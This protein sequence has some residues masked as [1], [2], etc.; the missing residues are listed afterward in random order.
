MV[1]VS[2]FFFALLLWGLY[3]IT[4]RC[5][6][7]KEQ[8]V[9]LLGLLLKI[10]SALG[11]G[12]LYKY[13]Y[14][15]GDTFNYLHDL[16]L[17]GQGAKEGYYFFY[18]PRAWFFVKLVCPFYL[19]SFSNYWVLAVVLS[20]LSF[21]STWFFYTELKRLNLRKINGQIAL[22]FVPTVV[23]WTSG[24]MKETVSFAVINLLFFLLL[25]IRR[26][27]SFLVLH[28]VCFGLLSLLL[29]YLKYYLF[30]PIF[31]LSVLLFVASLQQHVSLRKLAL[32]LFLVLLLLTT[33]VSFLHPN[34]NLDLF[35]EA[36]FVNNHV[37]F[38]ASSEGAKVCF[39][40][41]GSFLSFAKSV[42]LALFTCL[43]RPILFESWSLLSALVSV[44]NT[45]VLSL[46]VIGLWKEIANGFSNYNRLTVLSIMLV[47]F[48]AVLLPLAAPN[49][50]SLIRYRTAYYSLFVLLILERVYPKCST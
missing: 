35:M 33:V 7:K 34:M 3:L 42:P 47:L 48:L 19:L 37:V 23:F 11:I 10:I 16:E 40:Y 32:R 20:V 18:Q 27:S 31:I 5:D 39:P 17:L 44:E 24:L 28:F 49:F 9:F 26:K 29:F 6:D 36:L 46:F 13:Y 4:I 50:G 43:F 25:R 30:A 15:G 21:I 2:C 12:C 45:V 22:F 8:A 14:S 41:D 1:V 38:N